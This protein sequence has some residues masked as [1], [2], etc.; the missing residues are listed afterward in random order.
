MGTLAIEK[1]NDTMVCTD[2]ATG[3]MAMAMICMAA[4]RRCHC[5]V[6][7]CQPSASVPYTRFRQPVVRSRT[8]A[9]SGIIGSSRNSRLPVR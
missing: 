9:K 5:I 3:M 2:T 8:S 6:V 4:S 1:S 7:P